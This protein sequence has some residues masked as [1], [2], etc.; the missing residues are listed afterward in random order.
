MSNM[1]LKTSFGRIN[2]SEEL[3]VDLSAL[4]MRWV[5]WDWR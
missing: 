2:S 3:I 5:K 1:R 4:C